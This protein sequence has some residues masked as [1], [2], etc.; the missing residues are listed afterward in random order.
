MGLADDPGHRPVGLADAEDGAPGAQVFKQLPGQGGP[1]FRLLPQRQDQYGGIQLF[2]DGGQMV[3]VAQID[4]LSGQTGLADGLQDGG[5]GFPGQPDPQFPSEGGV[6][7]DLIAQGLPQRQGIAVRRELPGMGQ[8]EEPVRLDRLR[9]I[10]RVIAVGYELDAVAGHGPELLLH[11]RR[12]GHDGR[13]LVQHGLLQ[14]F[15]TPPRPA[16]QAQVLEIEDPRPGIPEI[17]DPRDAGRPGHLPPD[18]VHRMRGTGG[19][20]YVHRMFP[21]VFFKETDRRADPAHAGI[22]DEQV[23]PQPHDHPLQQALVLAVDHVNL[24]GRSLLPGQSAVQAVDFGNGPADDLRFGGNVAVQALVDRLH[25]RILRRIDDR[26]P[27]L[28]REILGEFHP[29]LHP[30]TAARRPIIGYDQ[31]PS[32]KD[33]N[34]KTN[35]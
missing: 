24:G 32:H 10:V 6:F 19:N 2:P 31:N 27:A 16:R 12:D 14:L 5:V 11:Q 18:Q 28:G 23:A 15:V 20:D 13:R 8:V 7:P 1:V 29:S 35:S 30:G 33:T 17:G 21:E 25:L 9:I 34:V 22:G 26:L 3:L 4:Q